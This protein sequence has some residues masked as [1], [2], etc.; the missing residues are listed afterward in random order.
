MYK[1]QY[2]CNECGP[3][4]GEEDPCIANAEFD[5]LNDE[6]PPNECPFNHKNFKWVKTYDSDFEVEVN[7]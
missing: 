3:L 4:D 2:Q 6:A 7:E 5:N 1:V